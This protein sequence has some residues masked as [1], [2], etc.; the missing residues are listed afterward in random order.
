MTQLEYEFD[1]DQ[2]PVQAAE[3][4]GGRPLLPGRRTRPL[5]MLALVLAALGGAVLRTVSS[6]GDEPPPLPVSA[7][8]SVTAL[9]LTP[10]PVVKLRLELSSPAGDL[11]VDRLRLV[12]GGTGVATVSLTALVPAGRTAGFDLDLPLVCRPLGTG[13]L[14]GTVRVRDPGARLWR[15]VPV[16]ATGT[17]HGG[18]GACGQPA[19]Q[20]LPPGWQNPLQVQDVTVTGDRLEFT[21]TGLGG[22]DR[23]Q[24][25]SID[26][27]LLSPAPGT[28]PTGQ[29]AVLAPQPDCSR[30]D[31]QSLLPTGVRVTLIGPAGLI[32]R[33]AALGPTLA[34]WLRDTREQR[35]GGR[36]AAPAQEGG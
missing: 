15:E 23:V 30:P 27:T 20:Q 22:L 19:T 5:L 32:T 10:D 3:P 18:D 6:G 25:I 26:G 8:V 2:V 17:L 28:R 21:V 33:Y 36:S 24:G 7:R 16:V 1:L 11:Q 9:A 4:D 35:C 29:L 13:D 14:T 31:R 34:H 12:D